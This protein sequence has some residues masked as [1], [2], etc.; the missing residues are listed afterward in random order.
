[1]EKKIN[2]FICDNNKGISENSIS[3][4]GT[5]IY[6]CDECKICIHCEQQ[7]D[8]EINET[9]WISVERYE[10]DS[11]KWWITKDEQVLC[12][13]CITFRC[14]KCTEPIIRGNVHIIGMCTNPCEECGYR[15]D[16]EEC[17]CKSVEVINTK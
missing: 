16:D 17:D 13:E 14:N 11:T 10:H 15:C 8:S 9:N 7:F 1:M 6:I 12:D 3:N 2:C 4:D 5:S